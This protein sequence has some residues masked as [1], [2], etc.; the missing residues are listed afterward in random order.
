MIYLL[1]YLDIFFN[2]SLLSFLD[3]VFVIFPIITYE[4][5]ASH[6]KFYSLYNSKNYIYQISVTYIYNIIVS[7]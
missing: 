5:I 7:I 6:L 3:N 4:S 2:S 1:S